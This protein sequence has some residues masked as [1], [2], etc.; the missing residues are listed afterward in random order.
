MKTANEHFCA[1]SLK[2]GKLFFACKLPKTCC[3]VY[4][5]FT[6]KNDSI[7]IH[8]IFAKDMVVEIPCLL[9]SDC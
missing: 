5:L 3:N 2:W 1:E 4:S 6:K 9:L 7:A 8:T